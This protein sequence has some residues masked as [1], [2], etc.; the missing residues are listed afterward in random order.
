[1]GLKS[2]SIQIG[3]KSMTKDTCKANYSRQK[4]RNI[5][6]IE[7]PHLINKNTV[8]HHIDHNPLNN[9]RDNLV[10]LFKDDHISYHNKGKRFMYPKT[11]KNIESLIYLYNEGIWI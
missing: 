1:M 11:I 6:K 3:L 4:A 9:N 10:I 2:G 7:F 8:V 5:M